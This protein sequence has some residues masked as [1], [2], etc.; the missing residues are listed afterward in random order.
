M[1]IL[2]K[3]K[4][5]RNDLRA[6]D[7]I[8]CN[9]KKPIAQTIKLVDKA[10]FHHSEIVDI[11]RGRV[12]GIGAHPEGCRPDFL[13]KR[14]ERK[15]WSDFAI[16]R[17]QVNIKDKQRAIKAA[18]NMAEVFNKYDYKLLFEVILYQ[19]LGIKANFNDP[20]RQICSEFTQY[21]GIK[22]GVEQYKP[23]NLERPFFTPADHLR[24]ESSL[25][26]VIVNFEQ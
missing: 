24:I 9:S 21:Y 3:Y 1:N 6:G 16:L 4:F 13:S 15:N 11:T 17:P 5:Y 18:Y 23:E 7:L 22:L 12:M 26:K 8:L 25:L 14:I 19:L 2:T 20:Y 10:G